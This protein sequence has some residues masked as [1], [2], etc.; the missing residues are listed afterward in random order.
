MSEQETDL[1]TAIRLFDLVE[2]F[3][4]YKEGLLDVLNKSTKVNDPKEARER[5]M[6]IVDAKKADLMK[7]SPE[8]KSIMDQRIREEKMRA[9]ESRA[10]HKAKMAEVT[11]NANKIRSEA[12]MKAESAR[13]DAN[14]R[15]DDWVAKTRVR[16][17]PVEELEN[18]T[19]LWCPICVKEDKN[20]NIINNKPS[21]ASCFHVLVPKS[22]LKNYN[23]A[24]RRSFKKKRKH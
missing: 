1:D 14:A 7:N 20:R 16:K 10:I 18:N 8:F 23:R 24:Y 6:K 21:C 5:I 9:D 12:M 15:V 22:E 19:E 2:T 17:A 4:E 3:D 11:A 13:R